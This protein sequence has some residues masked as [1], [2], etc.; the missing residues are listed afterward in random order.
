[1]RGWVLLFGIG[2]ALAAVSCEK[3]TSGT[4]TL[5]SRVAPAQPTQQVFQVKGAVIELHP[6]EKTVRIKHE[7]IPGYMQAM[8]MSFDVR[9][10]NELAGLEA[11]DTVTFRITVTDTDG[12]IDQIKKLSVP[13]TNT[14]PTTGP[15][16]LVR[17]VAPLNIGDPLPEYHFTNQLG[18]PVGLSQFRGQALAI[19]FIFTRCPYPT[20]CPLMASNF[21]E[22]QK[23]LLATPNA[24][25]NWHLLTLSFDPEWDTPPRLKA[26]A[27]RYG[28]DPRH[29]SFLTGE[30]ID[31]TAI[32]EQF[33]QQFWREGPGEGI[34]HNLRTVVVDA[35]G[36]VQT[37]L[38]ENKWKP[39]ELTAEIL[40]AAVVKE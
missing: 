24:P 15:F 39:E 22:V 32:T 27:E 19:T 4:A 11:G 21:E 35:H 34:S 38:R 12:W 6:E 20:F 30:L 28:C 10:T 23:Q 13:R 26:F 29:W 37:I 16:R 17:D 7:E 3:N 33:G 18:Q 36:R 40:K 1:M 2:L 14:L 5:A 9:D 25:T 31:I 8:T